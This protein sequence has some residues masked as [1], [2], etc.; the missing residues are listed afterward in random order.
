MRRWQ[1]TFSHLMIVTGLIVSVVGCASETASRNDLSTLREELLN[2]LATTQSSMEKRVK[3]SAQA[4]VSKQM[5]TVAVQ[6]KL[7]DLQTQ[8]EML[9]QSLNQVNTDVQAK[10]RARDEAMTGALRVEQQLL[11]EWLKSLDKSSQDLE[12]M[13]PAKK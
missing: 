1:Y 5:E 10:L 6:A 12:Q 9:Q 2:K 13:T 7:K 8:V 4:D 3:T 11:R